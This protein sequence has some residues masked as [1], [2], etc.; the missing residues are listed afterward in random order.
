MTPQTMKALVQTLLR[1]LKQPQTKYSVKTADGEEKEY[2]LAPEFN[3]VACQFRSDVN[4]KFK[5]KIG[6]TKLKQYCEKA[7]IKYQN[8]NDAIKAFWTQL[9]PVINIR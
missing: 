7:Q 2:K 6:T 3:L 5:G 4:K 8:K 1:K 9:E